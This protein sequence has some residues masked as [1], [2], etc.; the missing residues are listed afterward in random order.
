MIPE[1]RSGV[2]SADVGYTEDDEEGEEKGRKE[3]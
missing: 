3:V 2:L 1:I